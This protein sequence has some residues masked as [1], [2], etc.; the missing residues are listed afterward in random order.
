MSSPTQLSLSSVITKVLPPARTASSLASTM[1]P[2]SVTRA[3][4]PRGSMRSSGEAVM[5]ARLSSDPPEV[6]CGGSVSAT[7]SGKA[8][9]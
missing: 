8:S 1:V 3:T 6:A 9:S 5:L 7:V 2:L 4:P